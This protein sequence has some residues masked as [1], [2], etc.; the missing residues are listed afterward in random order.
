MNPSL[1]KFNLIIDEVEQFRI[2]AICNRLKN[3]VTPIEVVNWL[4]NF[5]RHEINKA[6]SILEKLEFITENEII[7][8]Y[9]SNLKKILDDN[10]DR[11]II[12]AV[13]EYGKSST[14]MVYYL[15]KTPTY[16]NFKN[17]IEF[18]YHYSNFKHKLKGVR[19]STTIIL[20]DDFSGSGRQF[21]KYYKTFIKP[22]IVENV[23][24]N[25]VVFLTLFYLRK[26]RSYIAKTNPEIKL[27]GEV[28]NPAFLSKG[29]VFGDRN[30]MVPLRD[31]C[32]NYGKNLFS[33]YDRDTKTD[34]TYPLGYENCQA[35]IVFAYN[36]P[37]NT[38][39]IIW[40]S[41]N[42][43]PLYPRTPQYKMTKSK[44]MRKKLAHEIGLMKH[45]EISE[46]FF[47]GRKDLGWKTIRFITKTDFIVYSII[48]LLK[49]KRAIP[50]ICQILGITENDFENIITE[51]RDVFQNSNS[52]TEYGNEIYME[53]NKQLKLVKK[54]IA[55]N[56]LSF[57]I[58]KTN[59]LPKNFKG[60]T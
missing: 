8:L 27:I 49:Q 16:L 22:Q 40:S 58:K 54:E 42:W 35:L 11:I 51:K 37:N 33:I 32:Y 2:D 6:L 52:L 60:V 59:Y 4:R 7:E 48:K 18:Y 3:S 10:P 31:F 28:R 56:E 13:S 57:D 38:L 45:S 29:S 53:I 41:K 15:K 20:L 23:N 55:S 17:R 5:K 9:D 25:N 14:L 30:S 50:I 34:E 36:T 12:H 39:P 21:V 44:E 24:I 46:V 19:N 26:A 1:T 43:I 47:S